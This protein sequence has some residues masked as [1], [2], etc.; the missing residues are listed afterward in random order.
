MAGK[1][2]M[3]INKLINSINTKDEFANFITVLRADLKNNSE[4][5]ENLTLEDFLEG[6]EAWVQAMDSYV[7]NSGDTNVLTPSWQTFG[8][9][10]LAA[11][12]YE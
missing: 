12:F 1:Q 7:K 4:G 2:N 9:I 6:M 3:A 8:K 11:K 10:L 5:W